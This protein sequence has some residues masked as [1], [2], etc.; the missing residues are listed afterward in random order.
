MQNQPDQSPQSET[1][2]SPEPLK[3]RQPSFENAKKND[4]TLSQSLGINT[5]AERLFRMEEHHPK[6][7]DMIATAEWYVRRLRSPDKKPETVV[8]SGSSGCGKTHIARR[9]YAFS[10]SYGADIIDTKHV[11]H[12][13]SKWFDWPLIAEAE[14]EDDFDDFLYQISQASFVVLDDVG[15]ES[16]RYKNGAPTSRLRRAL[17]ELRRTWCVLTSNLS[18]EEMC[19]HYDI[20]IAD[21]FREMAWMEIGTIPSYRPKKRENQTKEN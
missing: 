16:D 1:P 13:A 17:E 18:Q 5:F 10:K 19:G 15:S 21:R 3:P 4:G 11:S 8:F 9:I 2:L 7:S 12:W 20:R 6:V 14:D